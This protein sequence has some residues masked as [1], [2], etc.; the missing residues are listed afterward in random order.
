MENRERMN[1]KV[2][3]LTKEQNV[4]FSEKLKLDLRILELLSL[5]S[6]VLPV[7]VVLVKRR[8]LITRL[9]AVSIWGI[10]PLF[11][12]LTIYL[13]SISAFFQCIRIGRA[14]QEQKDLYPYGRFYTG[15]IQDRYQR[16]GRNRRT[17]QRGI[18]EWREPVF[19]YLN[20]DTETRRIRVRITK[21]EYFSM[22]AGNIGE[23]V[24]LGVFACGFLKVVCPLSERERY[25]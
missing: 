21:E 24:L 15:R 14:I 11:L 13:F 17:V 22:K 20:I 4:Y 5:C 7:I 8:E 1:H 12:L 2:T 19:Y 6:S 18:R 3:D 23:S 25:F 9:S 10:F 16:R